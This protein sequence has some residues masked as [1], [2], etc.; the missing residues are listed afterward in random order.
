MRITVKIIF[1]ASTF[2]LYQNAMGNETRSA[3]Q[4]R[5]DV[6]PKVE[7]TVLQEPSLIAI[8]KN[9]TKIGYIRTRYEAKV[10][11]DSNDPNGYAVSIHCDEIPGVSSVEISLDSGHKISVD[12][13][14]D[15][16]FHMP[17]STINPHEERMTF[18]FHLQRK[19]K[20]GTYPWP[21]HLFA[22]PL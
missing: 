20:T 4:V 14:S 13:G 9:D 8:E 16:I 7:L 3:I 1:L 6:A 19:A 18:R 10:M 15:A 12:P 22:F 21:I 5:A 2:F 11:I 17:A